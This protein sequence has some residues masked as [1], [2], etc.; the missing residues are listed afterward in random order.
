MEKVIITIMTLENMHLHPTMLMVVEMRRII[1]LLI[2][3]KTHFLTLMVQVIQRFLLTFQHLN[4]IE[5]QE[6]ISISDIVIILLPAAV[7][8][9]IQQAP[10][11]DNDIS[12][13]VERWVM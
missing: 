5:K 6:L 13:H 12:Q 11:R 10:V 8:D 4:L 3:Q 9:S 1:P 7:G 2:Q